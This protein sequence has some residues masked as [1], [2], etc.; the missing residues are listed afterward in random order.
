MHC[1]RITIQKNVLH[2]KSHT[3]YEKEL[4]MNSV[5]KY[6]LCKYKFFLEN[7]IRE[8]LCVLELDRDSRNDIN[9][10]IHKGQKCIN[11]TS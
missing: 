7:H 2:L 3:L 4:K 8:N 10:T 9:I 5:S 1:I 6:K 11:W